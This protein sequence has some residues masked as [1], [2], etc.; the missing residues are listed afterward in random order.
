M[1]SDKK[2]VGRPKKYSTEKERKE[3][4]EQQHKDGQLKYYYKNKDLNEKQILR[5]INA[6]TEQNRV[7]LFELLKPMV[8]AC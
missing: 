6:M 8:L 5:K 4:Y 2:K 3:A 7:K 1:D